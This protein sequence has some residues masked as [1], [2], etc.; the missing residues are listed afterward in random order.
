MPSSASSPPIAKTSRPDALAAE[1]LIDLKNA[2]RDFQDANG[3]KPHIA[4]LRRWAK[5]GI[6]GHKL[7][8]VFLG[9]RMMT[10]HQAAVRFLAAING[11]PV[12]PPAAAVTDNS[13][14]SRA[15]RELKNLLK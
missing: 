9:N 5:W 1:G 14:A 8:T 11:A 3:R 6:R 12:L 4:T 7:E 15:G 13:A 2:A 10:S